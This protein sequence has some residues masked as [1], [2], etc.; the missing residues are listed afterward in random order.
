M[1]ENQA[2]ACIVNNLSSDSLRWTGAPIT[3]MRYFRIIG[4][5]YPGIT[6]SVPP[7]TQKCWARLRISHNADGHEGPSGAFG[8][9]S[10]G[11]AIGDTIDYEI[12]HSCTNLISD[13]AANSAAD[14]DWQGQIEAPFGTRAFYCFNWQYCNLPIA[15][16]DP[17]ESDWLEPPDGP[18][19]YY[20]PRV[21]IPF[22]WTFTG[23]DGSDGHLIAPGGVVPGVIPGY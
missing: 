8:S 19:V 21:D 2:D 22:P 13:L 11:G 4:S 23:L 10:S 12:V 15:G 18:Q 14:S 7:A 17:V 16:P 9:I 3:G 1:P 6:R 20:G 5:V